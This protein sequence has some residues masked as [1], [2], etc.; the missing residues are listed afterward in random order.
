[1]A[2]ERN[3]LAGEAPEGEESDAGGFDFE[4][5]RNVIGF[6]FRAAR[7]RS[8]L[9]SATFLCV[10]TLGIAVSAA[11]PPVY[12]AKVQ[13]L[14][15]RGSAIRMLSSLNPGMDSVDSPTKNVPT[16][17][18]RFDN[19]VS[20]AKEANLVRRFQ[21]TRPPLLRLK[22]GLF[23]RVFGAPSDEDMLSVMAFTLEKRLMVEVPD[24]ST[25]ILSAEW[26]DPQVAYDLVT[27]VQR[28]FQEARYDSDVAVINDS[29]A[30][31]ED[32]AKTSLERVD[33]ELA[34]YRRVLADQAAAQRNSIAA[35]RPA[36]VQA[37]RMRFAPP[38]T[39]GSAN[40]ALAALATAQ[41]A[42]S[43]LTDTLED[44]RRRIKELEDEQ[45]RTL[46]S[47]KQQLEQAKLTLT[48]MHPTVI[49]L[50]QRIEAVT[51]PPAELTQLRTDVRSLMAQIVPSV[52]P[53]PLAQ[54]MVE[55]LQ[56]RPPVAETSIADAGG[57]DAD[58]DGGL[59][60]ALV[61]LGP[62]DG[63][64]WLEQSK[65]NAAIHAYQDAMGRIDAARVELDV[66]STAYKHRYV[67]INPAAVPHKPKKETARTVAVGAVVGGLLFAILLA[68]GIDLASGR[69]LEPWQVRKQSR[70]D[71]LA[72]FDVASS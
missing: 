19:L 7:R 69:I 10:A 28:N 2:E 63:A 5:V 67:V 39:A 13:L 53:P 26:S 37:R 46:D 38:V 43:D 35:D 72:E 22:D 58:S 71:V 12:T 45:Q 33:A 70:L 61:P 29:I 64:I 14:A 52:P 20:L 11:L 68:A 31:L 41:K 60:A 1:M 16:T 30:V 9:V 44:K 47:L 59:A 6:A 56:G 57:A 4:L 8:G 42:S 27:L 23:A 62:Q 18:L 40:A 3:N 21:S 51:E 49:A 50:E 36:E 17:I 15:Q 24:D 55:P 48:P 32:R 54:P 25:V 66:T 34:A 65:L